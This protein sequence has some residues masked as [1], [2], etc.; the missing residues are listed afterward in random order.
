MSPY[1]HPIIARE[2]WPFVVIALVIALASGAMARGTATF[3][4]GH[5]WRISKPGIADSY[6]LGT[7]HIADPRIA[8]VPAPALDALARTRLLAMEL[9]P[10]TAADA[11]LLE[12]EGFDDGRRLA[13]LV[14]VDDYAKL[15]V[16]KRTHAVSK[17]RQLG[18]IP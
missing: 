14:G 6:V 10:E 8:T 9:I 2:G 11:A 4:E 5:L 18:L 15:D 16:K 7:I 17:A 3:S 1:P 13:S 12:Q